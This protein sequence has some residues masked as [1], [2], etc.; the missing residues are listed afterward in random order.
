MGL[1]ESFGPDLVAGNP[2]V[3]ACDELVLRW[4][5]DGSVVDLPSLIALYA[6]LKRGRPLGSDV[7]FGCMNYLIF[8]QG[9]LGNNAF[10]YLDIIMGDQF[11]I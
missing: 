9:L 5:F 4:A 11:P 8:S 6:F 1:A 3:V 7:R 10:Q 2:I